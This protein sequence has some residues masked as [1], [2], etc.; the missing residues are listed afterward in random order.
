MKLRPAGYKPAK[1]NAP[2]DALRVGE[3]HKE[4]TKEKATHGAGAGEQGQLDITPSE[5]T[6]ECYISIPGCSP[7]VFSWAGIA[8]D[9]EL[10]N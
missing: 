3:C 5:Q 4:G 1:P 9:A 10:R 2:T 7:P 6:S 8:R